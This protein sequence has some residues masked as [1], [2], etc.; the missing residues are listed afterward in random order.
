MKISLDNYI[1]NNLQ[2]IEEMHDYAVA[3]ETVRIWLDSFKEDKS[4]N[5]ELTA[6]NTKFVKEMDEAIEKVKDTLLY[7]IIF[8]GWVDLFCQFGWNISDRGSDIYAE[9]NDE[10]G[11]YLLIIDD[12]RCNNAL[13]DAVYH[14]YAYD[15]NGKIFEGR[16]KTHEDFVTVMRV[17][18]FEKVKN[19]D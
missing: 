4:I 5:I 19:I 10:N 12:G 1:R 13:L 17:L 8:N 7:P 14:I 18:G 16:I 15:L 6:D 11:T 2:E 9:I 3:T